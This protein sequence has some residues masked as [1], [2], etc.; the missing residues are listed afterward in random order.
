M[1]MVGYLTIKKKKIDK[2]EMATQF[3]THG[4]FLLLTCLVTFNVLEMDRNS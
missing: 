2:I 1:R 4:L 3:L